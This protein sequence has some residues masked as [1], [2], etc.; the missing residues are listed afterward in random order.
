MLNTCQRGPSLNVLFITA[1]QWRADCLGV[2]GTALPHALPARTPALDSFARDAV[3]FRRHYTQATPCGPSRAAMLTGTY[4]FNNRSI[5]NGTP[6]DA[7]HQTIAQLVRRHGYRPLLFGYSDTSIDPRNVPPGDPRLRT[8]EGVAPGFE[9]GCVLLEDGAP[10]LEHLAKR[11]YGRLTI[12]EIYATGL[13]EPALFAAED[14]ETAFLTDRFLRFVEGRPREPWFAHLSFIKPHPPWVAAAPY[15][16]MIERSAIPKA[17]RAPTVQEE[18]ARHPYLAA[19]LE[20]PFKGWLGRNLYRP[21]ALGDALVAELRGIYLGLVAEL[22]RQLGRVLGQLAAMEAL[23]ETLVVITADHGEMLGDGWQLG[24]TGFRP[25]AFHVPLMIRH[26]GRQRAGHV[27]DAFT[28]HVDLMP[29]ILEAIGIPPPRQC[30]GRSLAP[31]LAGQVPPEWRDGVVY[32]HD[33][34]DLEGGWHRTALGLDDDACGIAVRR[35]SDRLYAH[36]AGLPA[37]CWALDEAGT[38]SP[39]KDPAVHLAEAQALL[40]H[41]MAHAERRL[42]GCLL[43]ASGPIGGYDPL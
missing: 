6:L 35:T 2:L 16:A 12:E 11:G 13:G 22:D 32:E 7:R 15:H 36:F 4:S 9:P 3:L 38:V 41:R 19:L 40:S 27:V 20:Q 29:T 26:P 23:D 43:T 1:D 24:K 30:D 39:I 25:E 5:S 21:A 34:R 8:Y 42:T 18:A 14:S 28:E 17:R 31:L 33:F 10:W 37:L